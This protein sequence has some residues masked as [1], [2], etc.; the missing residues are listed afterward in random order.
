[1]LEDSGAFFSSGSPDLPDKNSA[2]FLKEEC[3]KL[4]FRQLL[5]THQADT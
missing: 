3:E 1:M 5:L 2:D 4:S